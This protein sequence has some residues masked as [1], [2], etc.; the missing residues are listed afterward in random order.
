MQLIQGPLLWCATTIERW[1][2]AAEPFPDSPAL[3]IASH[4]IEIEG[5]EVTVL[6]GAVARFRTEGELVYFRTR[7][8]P[9][10]FCGYSPVYCSPSAAR[11]GHEEMVD[12]LRRE[13]QSPMS[14]HRTR[15]ASRRRFPN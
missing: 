7:V 12:A 14:S 3:M 15:P 11:Q 13:R 1:F 2:E 10:S 5:K 4:E 9:A 8:Q 6:T